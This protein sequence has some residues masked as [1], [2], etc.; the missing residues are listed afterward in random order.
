VSAGPK[1]HKLLGVACVRLFAVVGVDEPVD[2]DEQRR[3]RGFACKLV[4][5]VSG[6]PWSGEGYTEGESYC[7]PK[8]PSWLSDRVDGGGAG[9]RW[10]GTG[11]GIGSGFGTGS[12]YRPTGPGIGNPNRSRLS[13]NRTYRACPRSLAHNSPMYSCRARSIIWPAPACGNQ[14][15]MSESSPPAR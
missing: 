7:L 1:A 12:G 15:N 10:A 8:I 13:K 5:H 9:G 3:R 2:V 6:T 11:N 4:G 14:P